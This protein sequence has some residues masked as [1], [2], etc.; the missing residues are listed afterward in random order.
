[1]GIQMPMVVTSECQVPGWPRPQLQPQ[2]RPACRRRAV[3]PSRPCS[4]V[5]G[6]GVEPAWSL[7]G[8]ADFKSA[9][10]TDFAIRAGRHFA[11]TTGTQRAPSGALV[12]NRWRRDPESNRT[13]RICNPLHN[14]FA[15][16][17]CGDQVECYQE[18]REATA[19]LRR[20]RPLRCQAPKDRNKHSGAGNEART[21]DLN[22]GKVALYQLSYSRVAR[23]SS[24]AAIERRPAV[25][26][27]RTRACKPPRGAAHS[28]W[29]AVCRHTRLGSVTRGGGRR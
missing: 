7:S 23:I 5:P 8:P 4:L 28:V 20:L 9:A 26:A 16:A 21:R 17:P 22:L 6:A 29:Q 2:L 18:E 12:V 25:Y 11:P 24:I 14:R 10:S 3:V 19:S 27:E 1:M 15:I 13:R